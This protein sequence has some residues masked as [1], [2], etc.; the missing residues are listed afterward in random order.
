MRYPDGPRHDLGLDELLFTIVMTAV[1][2]AYARKPRPAGHIIGLAALIY[3]PARF[4]FDFLRAT[5]VAHPD[6][7]YLA[8]TPAQWACLATVGPGR[9]PAQAAAGRA[10]R[11]LSRL[12]T[13]LG[14]GNQ[15]LVAAPLGDQVAL[16]EERGVAHER[17]QVRQIAG[18]RGHVVGRAGPIPSRT[19]RPNSGTSSTSSLPA[20]NSGT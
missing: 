10:G 12:L 19:R 11:G 5:D 1:L 16:A 20:K 17:G 7:R 18:P 4:G 13:S 8:L 6:K 3:A 2:F 14:A 15:V 9:P